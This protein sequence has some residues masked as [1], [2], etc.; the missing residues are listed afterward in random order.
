MKVISVLRYTQARLWA[1]FN[2]I[3]S[4]HFLVRIVF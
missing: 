3:R 1:S 2:C 4:S